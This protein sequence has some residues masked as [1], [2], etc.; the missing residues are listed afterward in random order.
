MCFAERSGFGLN[1]LLGRRP[2]CM[3]GNP[4]ADG[5]DGRRNG[6]N[7]WQQMISGMCCIDASKKCRLDAP[8]KETK[9]RERD[10]RVFFNGSNCRII[11]L[12]CIEPAKG[13]PSDLVSE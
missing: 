2:E 5:Y 13:A 4:C 6:K 11:V 1:A 10:S 7:E 8:P 9:S 3:R 12:N